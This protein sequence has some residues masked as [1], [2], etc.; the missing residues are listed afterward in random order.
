MP[1][2]PDILFPAYGTQLAAAGK[3]HGVDDLHDPAR[4]LDSQIH[5]QA[6]VYVAR[7]A[8][9]HG[10]TVATTNTFFARGIL[11]CADPQRF[12]ETVR[13][14]HAL[15]AP[16]IGAGRDQARRLLVAFGPLG[17]CY[18]HENAPDTVTARDFHEQQLSVLEGLDFDA[19]LAETLCT[20]REAEGWVLAGRARGVPVIPS[21]VVDHEGKLYDGHTVAEA[22][23]KIRSLAGDGARFSINCSSVPGTCRALSEPGTERVVL[24]YPNATDRDPRSVD[25]LA[26]DTGQVVRDDSH[27][28]R[29]EKVI[30]IASRHPHIQIV[31]GCCGADPHDVRALSEALAAG[32][33]ASEDLT[34]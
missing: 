22:I 4:V 26:H 11:R 8:I 17:E 32:A 6:T 31:G 24:I 18:D 30:E 20:V 12:R 14:H 7:H 25:Y 16:L 5:R 19:V 28:V 2:K 15:L 23:A 27:A 33:E 34:A 3:H 21:F 10:A 9:A 1:S 13:A 29:A